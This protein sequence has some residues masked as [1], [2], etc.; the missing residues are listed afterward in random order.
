M[1]YV[2]NFSFFVALLKQIKYLLNL[3]HKTTFSF[4]CHE[5]SKAQGIDVKSWRLTSLVKATV[6][7]SNFNRFININYLDVLSI[8]FSVSIKT[9]LIKFEWKYRHYKAKICNSVIVIYNTH[10]INLSNIFS[11]LFSLNYHRASEDN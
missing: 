8:S 1:Y 10:K 3:V 9:V 11:L 2:T 7:L 4:S 5:T 6:R